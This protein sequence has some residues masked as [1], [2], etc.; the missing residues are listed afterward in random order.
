MEM[1]LI[2]H[3]CLNRYYDQNHTSKRLCFASGETMFSLQSASLKIKTVLIVV[4][5]IAIS[6][7]VVL[8]LQQAKSASRQA[9]MDKVL[10]YARDVQKRT[11]LTAD[12]ISAGIAQLVQNAAGAPCSAKQIALMRNIDLSYSYI[13]AIG[14]VN[15]ETLDCSSIGDSMQ[16]LNIGPV[17]FISKLGVK[18][19]TEVS[20]PF[21]SGT[22]FAVI[23][24]DG[25]AA[26]INKHLPI[27]ATTAEKDVSLATFSLDNGRIYAS[28]GII[29][30]EWIAALGEKK[31]VQFADHGHVVAVVRSPKYRTG[32]LAALPATYIDRKTGEL[33]FFLLPA[34]F[35][36][37]LILAFAVFYLIR[38][39]VSTQALL[40]AGLARNEFF[41][42]YQPVIDLQTGKCVGA[43]AL[44]RWQ[45][46]NGEMVRPDIFI[47]EAEESGLIHLIT[48]RVAR[49]VGK[50]AQQCFV[51]YPDFHLAINLSAADFSSE[52][53]LPLLQGLIEATHARSGSLI[54][55]ATER[56]LMEAGQAKTMIGKIRANGL[57]IALD[58][59]GTGYSSLSYL[60]AFRIDYLKIDKSFVD[61][62]GIDA[63]TSNVIEHIIEL[64]KSMNMKMIAEGVE[65]E[66]Q[67][68]F[69]RAKGVQYAQGWLFGKPMPFDQLMAKVTDEARKV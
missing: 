52:R 67:A 1:N 64:A 35:V 14:H 21:V 24:R 56:C 38:S 7:P 60:D 57:Q 39:Q 54:V 15:G 12:Q 63:P 27:D 30:P 55:E 49:L 17:D 32:A 47:P 37:G 11:D 25:Y 69:L 13:Q 22:R 36:G 20:F 51:A 65:T 66:A 45:R 8:A 59:F 23:E 18:I 2:E 58:D 42:L 48:Q 33:A 31:Y 53:T 62:I 9:E 10:S 68:V 43:E 41:M 50:D 46:A 61:K 5:L 29:K 6:G 4:I 16:S 28:T 40:K 3:S 34:G 19:R 44:M 26:I